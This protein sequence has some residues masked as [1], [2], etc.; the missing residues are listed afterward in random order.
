MEIQ[1]HVL[2]RL[3]RADFH[4]DRHAGAVLDQE[5]LVLYAGGFVTEKAPV[6]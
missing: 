1:L 6:R 3:V 5:R 2:R 4:G